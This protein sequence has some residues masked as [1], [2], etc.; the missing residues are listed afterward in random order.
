MA[1]YHWPKVGIPSY[2]YAMAAYIQPMLALG[3]HAY[4][5]AAVLCQYW[6][7]LV[8]WSGAE[9]DELPFAFAHVN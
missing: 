4:I 8:M 7:R 6:P 3:W 5:T 1:H 9:E 2:R